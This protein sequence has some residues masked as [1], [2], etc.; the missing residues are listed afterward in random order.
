MI[1]LTAGP[2]SS[3]THDRGF[4]GAGGKLLL[5]VQSFHLR[6]LRNSGGG[7]WWWLQNDVNVPNAAEH[8]P[9]DGK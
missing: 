9:Y 2:W 6:Q 5:W 4:R 8:F 7:W 3:Q 1:P